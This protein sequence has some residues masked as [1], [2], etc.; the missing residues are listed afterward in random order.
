MQSCQSLLAQIFQSVSVFSHRSL[1]PVGM[2]DPL[3]VTVMC[4]QTGL[5]LYNACSHRD[6]RREDLIRHVFHKQTLF[7]KQTVTIVVTGK[8]I[9]VLNL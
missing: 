8:A 2:N 9:A 3:Q 5:V 1:E 4:V 7:H 6:V